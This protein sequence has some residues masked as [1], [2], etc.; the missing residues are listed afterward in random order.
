MCT[1]NVVWKGLIVY[2]LS[3]FENKLFKHESLLI[4][5]LMLYYTQK[6][7]KLNIKFM[8]L[9]DAVCQLGIDLVWCNECFARRGLSKRDVLCK[10][11]LKQKIVFQMVNGVEVLK[12]YLFSG[13]LWNRCRE[14]EISLDGTSMGRGEWGIFNSLIDEWLLTGKNKALYSLILFLPLQKSGGSTKVH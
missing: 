11:I 6:F 10:E 3:W 9:L 5:I 8:G 2:V 14:L 1:Q 4:F 7:T 13:I 12:L